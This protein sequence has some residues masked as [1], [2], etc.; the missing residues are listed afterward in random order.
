MKKSIG[1]IGFGTIGQFIFSHLQEEYQ[2]SF[3]YD[4]L[5]PTIEEAKQFHVAN[6][7]QLLKK[8][9]GTDLVIECAVAFLL[10]DLGPDIIKA[11]NLMPFSLTAF[12]D[13]TFTEKINKLAKE[14]GHNVY[15]PHG[16]ILGLDGIFDGREILEK[17]SIT[18]I[19]RPK[20][21]GL[22]NT[23]LMVVYSGAT[24]E[25][26]RLFPRNV[27]VHAAL[28]LSGL[29]MDNTQSIIISDPNAPGNKH[30][31]E[32]IANGCNFNIEVL[33]NAG[34]GVTGAYTP[35]SAVANV[36]RVLGSGNTIV[37]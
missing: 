14:Y 21:L 18:T 19:K 33:S 22:D 27:N 3:I 10:V 34:K 24:R 35:V 23:E 29:G 17:V 30:V 6:R 1:L 12:A 28:A 8:L 37:I 4:R 5:E 11:S 36:R 26:C 2:I 32:V 31:I 7:D 13:D 25:A 20:N 16:A 9:A 15:I